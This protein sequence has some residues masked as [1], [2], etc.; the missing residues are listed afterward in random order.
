MR[1]DLG[2][3]DA[4]SGARL[5]QGCGVRPQCGSSS[6]LPEPQLKGCWRIPTSAPCLALLWR[7]E[8]A[9][10]LDSHFCFTPLSFSFLTHLHFFFYKAM[11]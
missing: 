3:G 2:V 8:R 4:L 10:S 1:P 5:P 6:V 11:R 9:R 7:K